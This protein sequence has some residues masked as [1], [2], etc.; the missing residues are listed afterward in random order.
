MVRSNIQNHK[1]QKLT[2]LAG[3]LALLWQ[4]DLNDTKDWKA[5]IPRAIKFTG[6]GEH[7]TIFGLES[8]IM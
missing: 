5:V 7:I 1:G 8:G 6:K 4:K 2:T 3:S